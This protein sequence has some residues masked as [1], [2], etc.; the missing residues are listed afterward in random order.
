MLRFPL[1]AHAPRKPERF[2]RILKGYL[3]MN[4]PTIICPNCKS[5]IKLWKASAATTTE[6]LLKGGCGASSRKKNVRVSFQK[7]MPFSMSGWLRGD[8]SGLPL[9]A[10]L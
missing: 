4:E 9:R 8:A 6:R 1:Y 3:S 5:E 2:A 10:I 7:M